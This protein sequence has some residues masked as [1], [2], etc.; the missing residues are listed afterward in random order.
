MTAP[1]RRSEPPPSA[2]NLARGLFPVGV[3]LAETDPRAPQPSPWPEE[4]AGL[5]RPQPGRLREFAAG[6]AAARH[7]MARLG[8]PARPILHGSD[9]APVWPAGLVGSI[10]HC[11]T[12][13]LAAVAKAG[14]FAALGLDLEEATLLPFDLIPA[15]CTD[16]EAERLAPLP[17]TQQ[18]LMAKLIFS[19]KE[20][21]YKAQYPASRQVF[22]FQTLELDFN[23]EMPLVCGKFTVRFLHAVPPFTTASHLSGNYVISGGL[24]ITAIALHR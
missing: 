14:S 17:E 5:T 16:A 19:A 13:C 9:R 22:G 21:A 11:S 23:A 20:C 12:T 4:R 2:L 15:I 18:G 6:R 24:I 3:A 1:A 8:E 10:S 7:A